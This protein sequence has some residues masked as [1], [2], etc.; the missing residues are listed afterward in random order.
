MGCRAL[1]AWNC[2]AFVARELAPAGLRSGP[3]LLRS[4][5]NRAGASS[6]GTN[7]KS[8]FLKYFSTGCNVAQLDRY[9]RVARGF[10]PAG[11]RSSPKSNDLDLTGTPSCLVGGP[12]RSPTGINP[13]AT[14]PVP[15]ATAQRRRRG[16][17][18]LA[19]KSSQRTALT[20][21]RVEN[22]VS[23]AVSK[24]SRMYGASS[25]SVRT[26]A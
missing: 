18:S 3:I 25:M 22:D 1:R 7:Y 8:M 9:S 12:L 13:L 14:R 21:S 16:G 2:R 20:P 23:L 24:K 11:L 17:D 10:I 19:T 15:C 26:A 4:L 5:R 6:Y